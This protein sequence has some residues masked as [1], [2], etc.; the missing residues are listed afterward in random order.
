M[1]SSPPAVTND[2]QSLYHLPVPGSENFQSTPTRPRSPA[3]P[4]RVETTPSTVPWSDVEAVPEVTVV[5]GPGG[6]S[7]RRAPG[8]R[9]SPFSQRLDSSPRGTPNPLKRFQVLTQE[10]VTPPPQEYSS[11]QSPSPDWAGLGGN[12][13]LTRTPGPTG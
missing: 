9:H 8:P 3:E 13:S 5:G 11:A 6:V 4:G 2:L 10:R 1:D 7:A 12:W